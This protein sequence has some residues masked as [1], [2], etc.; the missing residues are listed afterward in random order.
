M[1]RIERRVFSA[2]QLH[3]HLYIKACCAEGRL[4]SQRYDHGL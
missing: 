3:T 4:D 1:K 2:L